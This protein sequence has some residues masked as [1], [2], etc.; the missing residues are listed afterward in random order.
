MFT[1]GDCDILPM[2]W[3]NLQKLCFENCLA[4]SKTHIFSYSVVD[5]IHLNNTL[6]HV[7]IR[8]LPV[9]IADP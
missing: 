6:R 1:S 4:P 3:L 7:D 8:I 5:E 2:D 9:T